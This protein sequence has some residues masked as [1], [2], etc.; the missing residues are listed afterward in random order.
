VE[1]GG[2]NFRVGFGLVNSFILLGRFIQFID[3]L[4]KDFLLF[5][6]EVLSNQADF[7]G[8]FVIEKVLKGIDVFRFEVD[9]NL[10]NQ[11]LKALLL[12]EWK[13]VHLIYISE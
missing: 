4:I 1:E 2:L 7:G 6:S 11:I 3:N 8:V 12:S 5:K 9:F 13:I 10:G